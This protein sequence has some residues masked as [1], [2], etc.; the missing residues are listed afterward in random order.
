VSGA[1]GAE[2][3][4]LLSLVVATRNRAAFLPEALASLERLTLDAAWELVI[5]DNGSSDGTGALLR[6]FSARARFPVR[7]VEEPR[8]GLSRARNAGW[9]AARGARVAFTDDD[10]YPRP[11]YLAQIARGLGEGGVDFLGGRIL[12]HDP[13]DAPVTIQLR[14]ERVEIPPRSF[15]PPGLI[16]G[17]NMA[18][19][20]SVLERLDGFDD[21]LGAGTP[22]PCEDLDFLS[23]ASAAGF[24]GAYDPRPVVSHHHRRRA[25]E[26]VRALHRSYDL[27]RGAFYVKCLL[28]PA[29]RAQARAE[30]AASLRTTLS[31]L[32]RSPRS[33]SRLVDE[34]RGAVTYLAHRLARGGDRSRAGRAPRPGGTPPPA[35]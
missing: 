1:D 17:A 16:Q 6:G 8:P 14:N 34:L 15:V 2:P 18:A 12:L 11:D 31:E 13:G 4:P 10:C 9:R 3:A 29:R 20:R 28:D 25:P 24:T 35:R 26:Q 33:R 30:W 21:M 19:R 5:V 22:F 23:R 32:P 7:V 27:G